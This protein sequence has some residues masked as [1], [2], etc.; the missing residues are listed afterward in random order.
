MEV[1]AS[2]KNNVGETPITQ[3]T[4]MENSGNSGNSGALGAHAQES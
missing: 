3:N 1:I 4:A 2:D